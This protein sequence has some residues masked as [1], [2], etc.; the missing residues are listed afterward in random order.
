MKTVE[1]SL[2]TTLMAITGLAE[3]QR[4]IYQNLNTPQKHQ[5]QIVLIFRGSRV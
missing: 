4:S 3:A 1:V 2:L 5:Q